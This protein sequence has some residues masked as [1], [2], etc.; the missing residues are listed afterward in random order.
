MKLKKLSLSLVLAF[1]M[2]ISFSTNAL[3][4]TKSFSMKAGANGMGAI[5]TPGQVN[6][7]STFQ[8]YFSV[9]GITGQV[10]KVEVTVGAS[11]NNTGVMAINHLGMRNPSGDIQRVSWNGT[12]NSTVSY[13]D[14]IGPA[15]NGR[16][17]IGFNCTYV[18]GYYIGTTLV[19]QA[20]RSYKNA[21]LTITYQ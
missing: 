21:T 17:D 2:V 7:D 10:S 11:T 20:T 4:A 19:N 5:L 9:S 6:V 15:L 14:F 18:S 1:I 3:A 8:S 16:Y 12:A 13:S